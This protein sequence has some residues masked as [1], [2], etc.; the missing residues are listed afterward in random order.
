[1][2]LILISVLKLGRIE[3]NS[4]G[5]G[6]FCRD[7]LGRVDFERMRSQ[8]VLGPWV[9]R[10]NGTGQDGLKGEADQVGHFESSVFFN[11]KVIQINSNKFSKIPKIIK[12]LLKIF[13]IYNQ[14]NFY[15]FIFQFVLQLKNRFFRFEA[16]K[17]KRVIANFFF[18]I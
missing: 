14:S 17:D 7:G 16:S 13:K 2:R 6:G 12:Q 3:A 15:F 5:L 9:K 18:L 8:S 4:G 11:S 10:V 1:V